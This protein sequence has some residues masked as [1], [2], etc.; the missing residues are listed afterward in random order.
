LGTNDINVF[1]KGE[2]MK[3]KR[4]LTAPCGVDCF[5]CELYEET[6][7]D[8][9]AQSIHDKLGVPKNDVAYKGCLEQVSGP[10]TGSLKIKMV[11]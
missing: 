1:K 8:K 9:L 2:T 11:T 7:T 3:D 10:P 5:N 4:D 6:L